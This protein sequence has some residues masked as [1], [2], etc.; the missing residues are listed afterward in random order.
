VTALRHSA[1]GSSDRDSH[2][3]RAAA[4][5]ASSQRHV[6]DPALRDVVLAAL[7]SLATV[8]RTVVVSSSLPAKQP[9]SSGIPPR[10]SGA[11]TTGWWTGRDV[12]QPT[13]LRSETSARVLAC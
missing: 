7:G 2:C 4:S 10:P 13:L 1:L 8:E 6:A 9:F 11:P 12:E 3:A 5:V